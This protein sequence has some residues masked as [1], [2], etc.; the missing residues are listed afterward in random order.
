MSKK[1]I[2]LVSTHGKTPDNVTKEVWNNYAKFRA[3]ELGLIKCDACGEYKG[4]AIDDEGITA[5]ICI[6]NGI[7]CTICK[8]AII[9]RPISNHFETTDAKI[10]HT[11]YFSHA[12]RKC[13]NNQ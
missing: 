9:R 3:A 2:T 5:V 11:P 10:W 12:C 4:A 13:R 8:K 1:L 7:L 6:C